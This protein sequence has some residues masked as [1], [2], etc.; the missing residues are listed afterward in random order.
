MEIETN[1]LEDGSKVVDYDIECIS[2]YKEF[3]QEKKDLMQAQKDGDVL[4]FARSLQNLINIHSRVEEMADII[5]AEGKFLIFDKFY[6]E[7]YDYVGG[8]Y[9]KL[10]TLNFA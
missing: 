6:K 5:R 8:F 2:L 1:T 7:I 4:M 10:Q 9:K 3:L